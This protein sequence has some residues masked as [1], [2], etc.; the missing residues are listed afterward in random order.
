MRTVDA[1]PPTKLEGL[2]SIH[3]AGDEAV[4][5]LEKLAN[6]VSIHELAIAKR[7]YQE[8]HGGLS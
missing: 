5:R 2:Q 7:V 1:C 3:E 4:R 8:S 6:K